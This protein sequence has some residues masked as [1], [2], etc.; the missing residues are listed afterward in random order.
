MELDLLKT[1]F[2]SLKLEFI[3]NQT[4]PTVQ[5]SY[6][7]SIPFA[8]TNP[9]VKQFRTTNGENIS[10]KTKLNFW[11]EILKTFVLQTET[12]ETAMIN[13][14]NKTWD[15]QAIYKIY[16]IREILDYFRYLLLKL[17][18]KHK[19]NTIG[20]KTGYKYILHVM[21]STSHQPTSSLLR[22]IAFPGWLGRW[23]WVPFPK[24]K[25][26]H[27]HTRTELCDTFCSI[28]QIISMSVFNSKYAKYFTS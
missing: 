27:K 25:S 5:K 19:R 15:R 13:I 23:G 11:G 24:I 6:F 18:L 22:T 17:W 12:T 10:L 4:R 3:L 1:R 8:D 21:I 9:S 2:K 26:Q 28:F 20:V 7:C 16:W 14:L